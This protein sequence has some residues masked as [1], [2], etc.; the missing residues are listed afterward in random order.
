MP[1]LPHLCFNIKFSTSTLVC[2]C[3][4]NIPQEGDKKRDIFQIKL[5]IFLPCP[6]YSVHSCKIQIRQTKLSSYPLSQN[7]LM[8]RM[9]MMMIVLIRMMVL[10]VVVVVAAIC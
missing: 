5:L 7:F 8:I 2:E 6:F 10:M 4:R 1:A 3:E 9:I